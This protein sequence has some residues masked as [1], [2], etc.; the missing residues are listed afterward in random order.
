MV[1]EHNPGASWRL[2]LL[3]NASAFILSAL[4]AYVSLTIR[5]DALLCTLAVPI[6]AAAVICRQRHYIL[7]IAIAAA[8]AAATEIVLARSDPQWQASDSLAIIFLAVLGTGL[9]A[10]SLHRSAITHARADASLQS[11]Y[12]HN[13]LLFQSS[14]EATFT[15]D[16]ASLKLLEFNEAMVAR[17]GY[18]REELEHMSLPDLHFDED[19]EA[20]LADAER[21]REQASR[22]E[23]AIQVAMRRRHR[24]KDG[25]T[26]WV[27]VSSQGVV[28]DSGPARLVVAQDISAIRQAAEDMR[29]ILAGARCIVWH[30]DTVLDGGEYRSHLT[31]PEVEA[32]QRLLPLD[33]APGQTYADAWTRCKLPEDQEPSN[34]EARR[35]LESGLPGYYLEF[36]CLPK[37]G[38]IRWLAESVQID[39]IS[40]NHWRLVGVCTDITDRKRAEAELQGIAAGIPGILWTALAN[41][42]PDGLMDWHFSMADEAAAQ[43]ALP[44]YVAP[45]QSY[46]DAWQFS[47]LADEYQR[48]RRIVDSA[49]MDGKDSY[50]LEYRCR[51]QDGEIRWLAEHAHVESI[52]SDVWRLVGV[53]LDVTDRKN[54]EEDLRIVRA[55][56]RCIL[57][58]AMVRDVEGTLFWNIRVVDAQGAERMLPLDRSP[59]ESYTDA[60]RRSK[61]PEDV[62]VTDRTSIDALRSGLERYSQEYRCHRKDGAIRWLAEDVQIQPIEPGKWRL[63][64]VCTDITARKEAEETLAEQ[65]R[66]AEA[67]AEVGATLTRSHA[68][69]ESLQRCAAAMEQHLR[70]SLVLVWTLD[71]NDN[72]LHLAG[73][74]GLSELPSGACLVLALDN[75]LVAQATRDRKPFITDDIQHSNTFTERAWAARHRVSTAAEFPLIV[76]GRLVGMLAV[77]ST[78]T[79]DEP[80]VNTMASLADAIAVG[81]D[82]SW[83]AE[84]LR[85]Q[86]AELAESAKHATA[87]TQA[88]SEFLAMMS[89]EIRTPMNAIIGMT[90]LLLE[91]S[92]TSEQVE[93]TETIRTSADSLLAV[94]NDILDFSKIES[95]KLDLEIVDLDLMLLVEEAADLLAEAAQRKGL[96]LATLVYSDVPA[97]LRGDPGRIRQV[98]TNLLSNAIK[99]T[100]QGEVVLRVYLVKDIES[101][102]TLRFTVTDTGIGIA[103]EA[104]DRLFQSFSQADAS[105]TRRF[106]GTGLGLAISKQLVELMGGEIG[107]Q[108]APE[109]GSV[110]WFTVPLA[111][112]ATPEPPASRRAV[113]GLRVIVVDDNETNR[114]ILNYQIASWGMQGGSAGNG[115]EALDEMRR[116]RARGEPLDVAILD[117]RM[118]GMDGIEL[119]RAIKSDPV[120]AGTR[121]IMLSSVGLRDYAESALQAGVSAYLTKPVRQSQ[122]F[123]CL[124]SS[125]EEPSVAELS[126]AAPAAS[127]QRAP[128]NARVLIAEDNP[129][130]QRLAVKMFEKLGCRTDAVANGAEAVD[131]I[132][133]VPYDMVVMDCQ[134][135]EMDGYEA[136]S[137]IRGRLG[138]RVPIIALTANAMPEDRKRC[139]DAGMDD[140]VSKPIHLDDLRRVV[141][142]WIRPEQT[143]APAAVE[144]VTADVGQPLLDPGILANLQA[145]QSE[146]NPNLLSEIFQSFVSDARTK[147][148][149]LGEAINA[150]DDEAVRRAAHYLKGSSSMIGARNFSALCA[151]LEKAQGPNVRDER[152]AVWA[153]ITGEFARL[154][155]HLAGYISRPDAGPEPEP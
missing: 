41:R 52:G 56:A 1:E 83:Q 147:L 75:S 35:A 119:A 95:G 73:S 15:Y 116:A 153:P 103:P 61:I 97:R 16:L 32:A 22:G 137:E 19:R 11:L 65:A 151:Q 109:A 31:V 50:I 121:L 98:L 148:A 114:K 102:A 55:G 108:S 128:L 136:A 78:D 68:L 130:N 59:D 21:F 131:A 27:N 94:I 58:N 112:Q 104:Q 117:M 24:S 120:L 23:P 107:F 129:T 26:L 125:L 76:D 54:A 82:R 5:S 77:F 13:R 124:A 122:L 51:R 67:S 33:I 123:N 71:A 132:Q 12:G 90:G 138:L 36:R 46:A 62:E 139:L 105:T 10:E 66:I 155:A 145:L 89:H 18:T 115:V 17:Y 80:A 85:K 60:W 149:A 87:A 20:L 141:A 100:D 42:T 25:S 29:S 143:A 99:F 140:Y 43:R 84:A 118:P 154:D 72:T 34:Q 88:K 64:G 70:L 111:K 86:A 74:A 47:L 110:F 9:V 39:Q 2:C 92:L 57:W 45:G 101:Q 106:G 81:I 135:P 28:T 30:S 134:M 8:G 14:P 113:D 142:R 7:T 126:A 79:F 48:Q 152:A 4:S 133:R 91:T 40:A 49:L 144:P 3:V 6:I 69:N 93:M 37:T 127:V 96:E 38:E 150:G 146:S 53:C 44:L 63:V